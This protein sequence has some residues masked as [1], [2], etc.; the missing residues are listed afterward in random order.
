MKGWKEEKTRLTRWD[1]SPRRGP[2]GCVPVLRVLLASVS[3][4]SVYVTPA[5]PPSLPPSLPP[6]VQL[7]DALPRAHVPHMADARVVTSH[8]QGAVA[9]M[10][11]E[12]RREGRRKR[13]E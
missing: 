6:Y 11:R 8:D 9:L 5:L 2:S 10:A 12:G 3:A 7:E 4:I 13:R 1:A